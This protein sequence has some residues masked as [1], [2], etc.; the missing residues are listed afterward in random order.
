MTRNE[1]MKLAAL[2]LRKLSEK[3]EQHKVDLEKRAQA[4]K[5][6]TSLIETG[7]LDIKDV[8]IKVS[9]LEKQSMEELKTLDKAIEISKDDKNLSLKLGSVSED[10]SLTGED[11]ITTMLMED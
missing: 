1:A 5:I 8:L 11:P 4:E 9:E 6:V 7:H 10:I 3:N 2:S